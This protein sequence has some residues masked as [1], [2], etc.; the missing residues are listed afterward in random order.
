[1]VTPHHEVAREP[2]VVFAETALLWGR[3]GA[4]RRGADG[5]VAFER[6]DG[7]PLPLYAA[8]E[9]AWEPNVS[10]SGPTLAVRLCG[11]VG[12]STG[13][14]RDVADIER[15][16]DARKAAL[17]E[18]RRLTFGEGR[19]AEAYAAMQTCLAWDTIYEPKRGRVVS[20]VSRL[21][22]KSWGGYV[23]FCWD[24]F[25]AARM[26][27][28]DNRALA[29]ANAVEMLREATEDGFVPNF[30][31]D[32]D[33]KSRDRSQPPVGSMVIRDLYR[34]YGD[35]WLLEETFE[36][37]LRWNE[38]F[39]ARREIGGGRLA[40]GSDP[41]APRLDRMSEVEGVGERFGA[42][43]ESGLDNS[44]MYDDIPFDEEKRVLRLADVGLTGLMV[45]DCRALAEIAREIGREPEA[46]ELE[47]RAARYEAGL[48]GFW[49]E[50]TGMF[51]NVRTDTGAFDERLAPTMFYA[52]F[53]E[54][55]PP[56]RLA[57]VVDG[58]LLNPAQFG[59]RW[60]LPSISRADPAY[61]EQNYWRGRIWAP[62]NYL[63]YLALRHQGEAASPAASA[64][65]DSSMELLLREWREH[66][67]VHENYSAE[68]GSGCGRM[69]SDKFYHWG[70]LLGLIGLI[71]GGYA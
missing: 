70:G 22:N 43:L 65:A 24:T 10:A 20:T 57:R 2:A 9:A 63:V 51:H 17:L 31:G 71:E 47:A 48:R 39:A 45:A 61:G 46:L 40:W 33:C 32:E 55:L 13:R 19:C 12:F 21:W 59:G 69:N 3:P 49:N 15:A 5:G 37:L 34:R 11:A 14:P 26:A 60:M 53:G 7:R 27:A 36:G 66:G 54:R 50:A 38:W 29:Y 25:F 42:A 52:L 56:E 8:G 58:Y 68:D 16:L 23:L 44:P 41:Y 4:L 18:E 6:A 64:L 30:A 62:L 1:L 35:R 28:V 67:H